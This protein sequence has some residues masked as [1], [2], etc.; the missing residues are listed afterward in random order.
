[1]SLFIEEE[2]SVCL[3]F[4]VENTAELVVSAALDYIGCPYEAEVNLLLT[5]DDEIHEMNQMHRGIDRPT[6]V[7]S[8]P[9]QEYDIPG[10]FSR[11]DEESEDVFNPESGELMLGD[12]VISKDRVLAQAEQYGHSPKREYAFLIAHSMLHLFG[13]D[14]MEEDE[15]LVMEQ[16]QR[17]IMEK[18]NIPRE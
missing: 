3:P 11:F 15:R 2:G 8:F 7:L 18:V 6:D 1:M 4:D 16:K 10:D 13:Y 12:I 9:M 17:E 14:H 5:T